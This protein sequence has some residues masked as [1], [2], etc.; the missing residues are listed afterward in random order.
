MKTMKCTLFL[1]IL[2]NIFFCNENPFY[3]QKDGGECYYSRFDITCSFVSIV[4][5][6]S[7]QYPSSQAQDWALPCFECK[8]VII[9]ST[10]LKNKISDT[11]YKTCADTFI[12]YVS[13]QAYPGQLYLEKYDINTDSL[14]D[15][16]LMTITEGSCNP[17]MFS[18]EAID[19]K[20]SFEEK[21]NL[22]Q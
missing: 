15:A 10:S 5:A 6:D 2:L 21:G 22:T 7:T 20:D 16:E 8:Y 4:Q 3:G 14:Y 19:I 9:D 11:I 17:M 18:F 12:L 13:S 1:V